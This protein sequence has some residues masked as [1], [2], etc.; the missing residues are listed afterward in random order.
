MYILYYKLKYNNLYFKARMSE[1]RYSLSEESNN[2]VPIGI[3]RYKTFGYHALLI[4]GSG[5][6]PNNLL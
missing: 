6:L 1:L 4:S 5:Y 3:Q 2:T